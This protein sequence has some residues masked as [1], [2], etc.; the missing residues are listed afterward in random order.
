MR[1]TQKMLS[2]DS[3]FSGSDG[4]SDMDV[5]VEE[6]LDLVHRHDRLH[7]QYNI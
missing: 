3:S 7:E 1:S 4:E 6:D 5:I 2:Y